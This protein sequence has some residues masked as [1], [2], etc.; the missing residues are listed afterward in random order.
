[1]V[2]RVATP[3]KTIAPD[4]AIQISSRASLT[5][6]CKAAIDSDFRYGAVTFGSALLLESIQADGRVGGDVVYVADLDEHNEV[7]RARFGNRT[8]YRATSG[9]D[10]STGRRRAVVTPY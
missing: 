10:S 3:D 7:L 4:P 6:A 1:M 2:A 5:P 8:W 9:I